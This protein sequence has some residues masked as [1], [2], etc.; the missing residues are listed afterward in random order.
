[1]PRERFDPKTGDWVSHEKITAD[2]LKKKDERGFLTP[3]EEAT[4]NDLKKP[5][6]KD[7][8]EKRRSSIVKP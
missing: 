3:G 5:E 1:M 4:L 6:K 7:D 2:V 8:P